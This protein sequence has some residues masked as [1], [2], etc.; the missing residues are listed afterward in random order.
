MPC[1]TRLVRRSV[2]RSTAVVALALTLLT[3]VAQAQDDAPLAPD[4]PLDGARSPAALC[5]WW[6]THGTGDE[7]TP[8][9]CAIACRAGDRRTPAVVLR[10]ATGFHEGLAVAV[11]ER[12]RWRVVHDDVDDAEGVVI[13]GGQ[14]GG[15]RVARCAVARGAV[16]VDVARWQSGEPPDVCT[17]TRDT[18]RLRCA[19]GADAAW[20]CARTVLEAPRT[21]P[22]AGCDPD[23]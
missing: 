5:A 13:Q 16:E 10:R 19:I 11:R 17:E 21:G 6:R 9:T 8:R 2:H 12:G 15:L 3:L 4:W 18:T 22:R 23:E 1:S 20:S 14:V 7:P